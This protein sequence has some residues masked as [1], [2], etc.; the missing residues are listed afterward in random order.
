[1]KSI[2]RA[3]TICS[4][5]STIVNIKLP[6]LD[7]QGSILESSDKNQI[8]L[9]KMKKTSSECNPNKKS[10]SKRRRRKGLV[11][12]KD[13]Y[14]K[15]KDVLMKGVLRRCR[16]HF[17]DEYLDYSRGNFLNNS[18]N[19]SNTDTDGLPSNLTE[20]NLQL[21]KEAVAHYIQNCFDKSF[22]DASMIFYL[23]KP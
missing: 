19:V 1:M 2:V 21:S 10:K 9:T 7:S 15:R 20:S 14:R 13:T 4:P 12:K 3:S 16:K 17:Q 11:V 18:E 5:T 22:D 23:G 8:K 6:K